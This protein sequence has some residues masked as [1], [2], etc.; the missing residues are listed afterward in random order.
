MRR[1]DK[2]WGIGVKRYGGADRL[3]GRDLC[4]SD[5]LSTVAGATAVIRGGAGSGMSGALLSVLWRLDEDRRRSVVGVVGVVG[6]GMC[7][8]LIHSSVQLLLRANWA[9]FSARLSTAA[10]RGCT[11]IASTSRFRRIGPAIW[12][13]L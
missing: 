7:S 10:C 11:T 4:R 2:V 5:S 3:L 8:G 13:S 12:A 1:Y 6:G 9:S